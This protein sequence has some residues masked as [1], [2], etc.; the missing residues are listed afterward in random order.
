MEKIIKCKVCG[1]AI[2]VNKHV[3]S[4]TCEDCKKLK[5]R[6]IC[7]IC[8]QEKCPRPNIC[9]KKVFFK[10]LYRYFNFD[11]KTL[12]SIFVYSEFDRIKNMLYKEYYENHLSLLE[13]MKKYNY[14]DSNIR[15]FSKIFSSLG[16]KR[17]S[18]SEASKNGIF[19]SKNFP[20]PNT[21]RRD[22]KHG[23]HY[24]WD[25]KKVFYRSSY[26]LA[27]IKILDRIKITYIPEGIK[28]RYFDS[29]SKCFRNAIPDFFFPY[30]NL[31]VEVKSR[32]TYNKQNMK[33]KLSEYK[34]MGFQVKLIV[35]NN[36]NNF[37]KY[38]KFFKNLM[39][40]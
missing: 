31:I 39:E 3:S 18:L 33:D 13:I 7:K 19:K 1:K 8:G 28:I 26:E 32:F 38:E 10:T 12:G 40:K 23:W 5:H 29:I 14:R 36:Q 16:I 4:K 30:Y 22:Y 37:L 27:L 25:G 34:N 20:G 17:R 2:E 21:G 11:R 9:R 24:T 6:K 35:E 15:N